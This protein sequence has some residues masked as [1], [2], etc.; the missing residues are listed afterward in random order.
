MTEK[1]SHNNDPVE[2]G[3]S[4][5]YVK[6][7]REENAKWRTRVRELEGKTTELEVASELGRQNIQAE[8]QWVSVGEGESVKEAV[9]RFKTKYPNLIS[10]PEPT[11]EEPP[12]PMD[13]IKKKVQTPGVRPTSPDKT[14]I[15]EKQGPAELLKHRQLE[16]IKKDPNARAEMRDH[17]QQLLRNQGHRANQ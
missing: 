7:L 4:S 10:T 11:K 6:Q 3:F 15:N 13:V 2:T 16:E 12:S 14:Q 1:E 17:Y 8:P 9:E 5:D